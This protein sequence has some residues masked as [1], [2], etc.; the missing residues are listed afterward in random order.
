MVKV[1][2]DSN[3]DGNYNDSNHDSNY[4]Y[5]ENVIDEIESV[6]TIYIAHRWIPI[7]TTVEVYKET[8]NA[9]FGDVT[10]YECDDN[11]RVEELFKKQK[12]WIPKSMAD[13]VWWICTKLF[14]HPDKVSNR[15]FENEY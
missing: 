3:Y 5:A 4:D 7:E 2:D 1:H 10:V 13:N 8:D 15:R 12:T 9:Y 6:G 14:E 11:G